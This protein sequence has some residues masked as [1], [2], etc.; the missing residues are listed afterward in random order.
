MT[1]VHVPT[2]TD[3]DLSTMTL[4]DL[5][6][7]VNVE[8][9][10]CERDSI[11]FKS[12]FT[13]AL[14]HAIRAG[15]ALLEA[16]SRIPNGEWRAWLTSNVAAHV[17]TVQ[18]YMRIAEFRSDVEGWLTEH[19][20]DPGIR[21]AT[22]F[23]QSSSRTRSRG[24]SPIFAAGDAEEMKALRAEGV[25]YKEIG[26]RFETDGQTVRRSI[27]PAYKEACLKAAL[28]RRKKAADARRALAEKQERDSRNVLARN[29]GG[30]LSKAYAGV[31]R[32]A[33]TLDRALAASEPHQRPSVRDA[34]AYAHKAEDALVA[35]MKAQ[36]G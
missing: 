18:E 6:R 9:G 25:S 24:P 3:V 34:L 1:L 31:R 10:L 20:G 30:E 36:P 26:R 21:A 4:D 5:V 27:D 12:A 17:M 8:H 28:E 29:A 19:P 15:E 23:L 14:G 13:G 22:R 16:K 11:T 32:L 2:T 7:R 35:A 33:G